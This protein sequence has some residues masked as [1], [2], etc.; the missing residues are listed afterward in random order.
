GGRPEVKR[1]GGSSS[2][3]STGGGELD[4]DERR[5]RTDERSLP[6]TAV[7]IH[8]AR[9][10]LVVAGLLDTTELL[11]TAVAHARVHRTKLAHFVPDAFRVRLAPIMAETPS[12]RVKDFDV[13]AYSGRRRHGAPDPLHAA[14]AGGDGAFG[15]APA[16]SGW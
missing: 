15:F 9:M 5:T 11:Q 4:C 1:I 16:G 8:L 13:V 12:Q 10:R 3:W 2:S 6:E 7:K 14:L